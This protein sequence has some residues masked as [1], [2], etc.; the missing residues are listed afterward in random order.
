MDDKAF[1]MAQESIVNELSLARNELIAGRNE[2][3]YNILTNLIDELTTDL[4][5]EDAKKELN[6]DRDKDN[7]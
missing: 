7:I 6:D 1:E 3:V 5:C 4:I 2:E